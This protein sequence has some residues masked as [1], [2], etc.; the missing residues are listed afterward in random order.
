VSP[1]R[2]ERWDGE[3]ISALTEAWGVP[4]LEAYRSIGSTNDRAGALVVGGCRPYS[5][6]VA[7]EQSAGRGRRGTRWSSPPGCGLWMSV[8]LG[9]EVDAVTP[10]LPLLVG[11]AV[12]EALETAAPGLR[13]AIK[14]P[15]DLLIDDLKV[16][17]VL[18]ERVQRSVVVGVGVNLRAPPGGLD[19]ALAARATAVELHGGKRIARKDLGRLVVS[20]IEALRGSVEQPLPARVQQALAQRDALAGRLLETEQ[21]GAGIGAGISDDGALRLERPDGSL[22]RVVGGSVRLR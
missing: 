1:D 21:A 4:L 20:G 14:W 11:L 8:V 15:N 22:V 3:A 9:A 7:D 6:V 5:V 13:V 16:G 12:A 17:G 19:G 2:L 18:C 10:P